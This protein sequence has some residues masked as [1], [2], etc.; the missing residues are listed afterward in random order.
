MRYI[1]LFSLTIWV[2]CAA[3]KPASE[4][5]ETLL[6]KIRSHTAAHLARLPHYTC[7]E[8]INR[9]LRQG[10]TWNR[11]DTVEIEVAIVDHEELFAKAGADHFEER[12]IDRVVP[13]GTI[14]NG[15]FGTHLDILFLQHVATFKYAGMCKK[16]GHQTYR[17]DFLVPL[18]KSRFLVKHS[19]AQ[20]V[21]PYEGTVWVDADTL[22]L[23]R[24]D[25]KVKHTARQLGIRSIEEVMHYTVMQIGNTETVLPHKSELSVTDDTGFYSLNLVELRSCREFQSDSIVKYEAPGQGSA[26]RERQEQ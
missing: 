2:A 15:S 4:D 19:G 25:V 12:V 20:A 11:L 1:H 24:V 13:T 23:V 7:H 18:E 21:V 26:A 10:S 8:V 17:Y 9:L 6:Q 16:D 3:N 22:D 5:P 14:G